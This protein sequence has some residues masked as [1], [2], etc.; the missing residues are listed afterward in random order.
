MEESTDKDNRMEEE[1]KTNR[2]GMPPT[3]QLGARTQQ[4]LAQES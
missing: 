3:E 4:I 1:M 2:G